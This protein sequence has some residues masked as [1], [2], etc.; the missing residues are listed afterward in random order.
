VCVNLTQTG[1]VQ[2]DGASFE[3]MALSDWS[4]A[5]LWDI[6][7]IGYWCGRAQLTMGSATAMLVVQGDVK[8][9]KQAEQAVR[10]TPASSTPFRPLLQSLPPGS[11][12]PLVNASHK[13]TLSALAGHLVRAILI[14]QPHHTL[15]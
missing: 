15:H 3:K 2:E 8:K 4:V 6:F 10:N 1:V 5:K 14:G 9:E 7:L 13:P 11:Y 12:P